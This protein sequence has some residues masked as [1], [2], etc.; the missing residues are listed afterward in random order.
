ML[1]FIDWFNRVWKR[2]PNEI[3]SEMSRPNPDRARIDRLGRA[4][5]DALDLFEGMLTGREH[6]MGEFSAAD[7]CA[8]PFLK[9]GLLGTEPSDSYLF[10]RVLVDWQPIMKDHPHLA[11]WIRRVDKCPRQA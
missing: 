8:F 10:H 5:I 4:I 1:I 11:D 2:P 3:E 9:Y 7:C 6:L